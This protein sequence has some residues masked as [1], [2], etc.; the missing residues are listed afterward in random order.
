MTCY[1][2]R[3]DTTPGESYLFYNGNDMGRTGVGVARMETDTID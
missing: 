1:P 2:A 3:L